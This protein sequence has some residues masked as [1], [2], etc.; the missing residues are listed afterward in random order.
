MSDEVF[1]SL[2]MRSSDISNLLEEH[3][4]RDTEGDSSRSSKRWSMQ[5]QKAIV[6]VLEDG[7]VKRNLS[8]VPR[9]LSSEG[10]GFFHGGFLH[11]GTKC[12]VTMRTMQ[13][14]ARPHKGTIK[15]CIHKRG[16]LHEIGVLFDTPISPRE[17]F[18]DVG[19]SPLFNSESV[20]VA[21]LT[22]SVLVVAESTAERR[23]IAGHFKN[24]NMVMSEAGNAHEAIDKLVNED[25]DMVF[26]DSDLTD[27]GWKEFVGALRDGGFVGPIV[28]LAAE[29]DQ[30]LRIGAITAGASEV[31]FKPLTA[32]ILHRAAAEYLLTESSGTT[33]LQ[34]M[35]SEL[36]ANGMDRGVITEYIDELQDYA[37]NLHNAIKEGDNDTIKRVFANIAATATGFGFPLLGQT[38]HD[39]S[40][41]LDNPSGQRMIK[42]RAYEIM[43]MCRRAEAPIELCESDEDGGSPQSEKAA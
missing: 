1:D 24:S 13:G 10:I 4:E 17:Y 39:A 20:D 33:G 31:I 14:L 9:N 21:R 28:L 7:G 19:D 40:A 8:V 35:I 3:K 38:A 42:L 34:P 22:G 43:K 41:V 12:Y 36:D 11:T 29:K 25:P 26:A 16:R 2:R 37:V 30:T 27:M 15:R 32:G 23:L 6:T 5:Q 18:I